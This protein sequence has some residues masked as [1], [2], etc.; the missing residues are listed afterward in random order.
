MYDCAEFLRLFNDIVSAY[1]VTNREQSWEDG[2]EYWIETGLKGGKYITTEQDNRNLLE[3]LRKSVRKIRKQA[4]WKF[5]SIPPEYNCTSST[6][7]KN[8]QWVFI[9]VFVY[10]YN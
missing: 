1:V 7:H 4:A 8:L 5:V 6:F 10:S 9:Y 2:H 3:S